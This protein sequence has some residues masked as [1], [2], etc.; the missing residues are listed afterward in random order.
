[1]ATPE[2][3]AQQDPAGTVWLT[4]D[5]IEELDQADREYEEDEK[6]GRVRPIE[7]LIDELRRRPRS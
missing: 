5:E 3:Q 1:M 6:A 7:E 2:A 4:P